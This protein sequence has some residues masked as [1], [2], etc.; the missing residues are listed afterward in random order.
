MAINWDEIEKKAKRLDE[1]NTAKRGTS[2][3]TFHDRSCDRPRDAR[4][5]VA[6]AFG[7]V[8]RAVTLS[9]NEHSADAD[10]VGNVTD[11]RHSP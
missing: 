5:A 11:E 7:Q 9:T 6:H 1:K 3:G 4:N 10:V 8:E 2:N